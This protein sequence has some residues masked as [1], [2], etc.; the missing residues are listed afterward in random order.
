MKS[1]ELT[2][3][4]AL[5]SV[6]IPISSTLIAQEFRPWTGEF[7]EHFEDN[8]H[9]WPI[10]S[11][12]NRRAEI[13]EGYYQLRGKSVALPFFLSQPVTIIK[14]DSFLLEIACTQLKGKKN[15]G[16]GLCWGARPDRRDCYVFLVSSNRKF[17][18][19]RMERGRYRQLQ[20]WTQTDLVLGQKEENTLTVSK[21]EGTYTYFING[22]RVFHGPAEDLKGSGCG[23]ILHGSMELLVDKFQVKFPEEE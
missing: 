19:V 15:M 18:I 20:P 3:F 12:S 13:S 8:F 16:Y 22:Q 9:N 4:L 21:A 17:T 1:S 7:I 14:E 2:C 10:S 11:E 23:V 5:I 6:L